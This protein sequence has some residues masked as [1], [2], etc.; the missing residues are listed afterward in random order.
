MHWKIMV[1]G[2]PTEEMSHFNFL[3]CD[4]SYKIE[5]D[6]TNKLHK[7]QL[8]CGTVHH[9]VH[10]KTTRETQ[11]KFYKVLAAPVL[12]Y[13]CETWALRK[14]DTQYI[15][16]TRGIFTKKGDEWDRTPQRVEKSCQILL[17]S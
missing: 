1:N 6:I 3:E 8:I 16:V 13:G 14:Q 7:Y 15:Q 5:I 4:I 9:T 11:L 17:I 12:T 2:Q 10:N